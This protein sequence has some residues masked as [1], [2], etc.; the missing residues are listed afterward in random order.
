MVG[1]ET[2]T[3]KNAARVLQEEQ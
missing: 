1:K 3:G 2:V